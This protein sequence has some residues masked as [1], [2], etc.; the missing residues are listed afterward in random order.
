MPSSTHEPRRRRRVAFLVVAAVLAVGVAGG[1]GLAIATIRHVESVIP[2]VTVV[3][4]DSPNPTCTNCVQITPCVDKVCN[5]LLLGS[6]SRKGLPSRFGNSTNSPGQ[7]S[8]TIIVVHVDPVHH[9]TVVLSIPRDL[10]VEIPGH[11]LNKINTAFNYGP[12]T[13]V[14]AVQKLTGLK[15]NHYV[16][17]NFLGFQRLVTALGGITICV[18][19]PMTDSYSGLNLPHKGCY[20]MNGQE[21][22]AFVRARHVQGDVIPDFS[23]IARQ[24]VFMRAVISKVLSAGSLIHLPAL[25]KA[26][27]NNLV[28]DSNL[29]IFQLQ[30]L[31]RSLNFEDAQKGVTFR[32]VP[33]VPLQVQGEDFVQLVEP[34]ASTLFER[35]RDGKALGTL[36]LT[37]PLTP[38][39]PANVQVQVLDANSNGKAA[40]VEA[41]LQH[42]GFDVLP[43]QSAPADLTKSAILWA[44]ASK[45]QKELVSAYLTNF[46]IVF[47]KVHTTGTTVTIVV[48]TDFPGL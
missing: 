17:V 36:G 29:D 6:D 22:L 1:S 16:E 28:L 45:D 15:I 42:A 35:I 31:T 47:D 9:R 25:V 19:R 5:Y 44:P 14:K 38:I 4:P 12:N 32:V 43:V 10:R 37:A 24:Q 8:D 27:E 30:D 26:V 7:R 40:Q 39:S 34:Q 46:D 13:T 20:D 2:R 41:Y 33:A 11:G 18:D 3:P 21:A 48:G 23:R